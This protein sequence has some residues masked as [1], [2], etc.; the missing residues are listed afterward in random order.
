L[1]QRQVSDFV[2]AE[3]AEAAEAAEA[4]AEAAESGEAAEAA[5]Q[6]AQPVLAVGVACAMGFSSFSDLFL[7]SVSYP[8]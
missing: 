1:T 8:L 3:V 4:A 7:S 6:G 5:Q 2:V